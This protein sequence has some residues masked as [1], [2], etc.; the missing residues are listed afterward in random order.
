M[1][2]LLGEWD[3]VGHTVEEVRFVLGPP[4]QELQGDLAYSFEDGWAGRGWRFRVK[5]GRIVAVENLVV[6]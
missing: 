1:E 6:N 4:V 2:Q 5:D 3:P